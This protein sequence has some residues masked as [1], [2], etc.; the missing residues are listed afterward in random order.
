MRE[1]QDDEII[2]LINKYLIVDSYGMIHLK[3]NGFIKTEKI[4]RKENIAKELDY[5]EV[6]FVIRNCS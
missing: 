1:I 3:E 6:L 5:S 4:F 2:L